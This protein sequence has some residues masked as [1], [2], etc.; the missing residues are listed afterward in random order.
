DLLPL[1][2]LEGVGLALE[3]L[4]E[5]LLEGAVASVLEAVDLDAVVKHAPRLLGRL[6]LDDGLAD[7]LGRLT[8]D[9]G[10][11][12]EFLGRPADAV[13]LH[14][15]R[16]RLNEINDVVELAG[17]LVNVLPVEGSDESPVE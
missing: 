5:R 4:A 3:E 1:H 10:E 6:E 15:R 8:Q 12:D 14:A 7:V 11:G 13:E 9:I 16:D 17:K 2:D